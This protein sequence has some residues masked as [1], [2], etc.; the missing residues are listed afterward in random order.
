MVD[1][2][3]VVEHCDI[4]VEGEEILL[5]CLQFYILDIVLWE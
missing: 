2:S 1:G 3:G 5:M 4:A